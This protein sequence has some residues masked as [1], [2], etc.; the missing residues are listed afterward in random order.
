MMLVTKEIRNALPTL[1]ANEE[2]S[3]TDIK[4]P[5]KLFNPVGAATWFITELDAD[6]DLAFGWCDL[7]FGP[8]FA[9]LGYVSLNELK[10]LRLPMGLSI[11]R[12]RHWD[13]NT[14]LAQVMNGEKS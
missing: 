5:L 4:M 14:T 7:G 2:L 9:E 11:E 3:S 12:D 1:Y 8:G 13:G 10:S 6:G